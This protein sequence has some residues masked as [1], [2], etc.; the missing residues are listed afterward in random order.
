L[1]IV[2]KFVHEWEGEGW[3][4]YWEGKDIIRFWEIDEFYKI[5]RKFGSIRIKFINQIIK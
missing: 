2:V 5:I 3:E 1:V 4:C